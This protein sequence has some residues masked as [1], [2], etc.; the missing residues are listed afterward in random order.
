MYQRLYDA[1]TCSSSS[2]SSSSRSRNG[3]I[4]SH[5]SWYRQLDIAQQTQIDKNTLLLLTFFIL[6]GRRT[7]WYDTGI[8]IHSSMYHYIKNHTKSPSSPAC[9]CGSLRV[10]LRVPLE[11][12]PTCYCCHAFPLVLILIGQYPPSGCG[13]LE[14]PDVSWKGQ[15]RWSYR[16]VWA[17]ARFAGVVPPLYCAGA[18]GICGFESPF[19]SSVWH[20]HTQTDRITGRTLLSQKQYIEVWLLLHHGRH[21]VH[22]SNQQI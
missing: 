13:W 7:G 10:P 19:S 5:F 22:S 17:Y 18:F 14:S 8:S 2:N 15:H 3:P 21:N 11:Y 4:A 6:Y 1:K 9:E 12:F 16:R 20:A